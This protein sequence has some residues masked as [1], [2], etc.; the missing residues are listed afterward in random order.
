MPSLF[1]LINDDAKLIEQTLDRL[2]AEGVPYE[3]AVE[4]AV[5]SVDQM[6]ADK[7]LSYARVILSMEA[8]AESAKERAKAMLARGGARQAVADRMRLRLLELLPRDF[9]AEDAEVKLRFQPSKVLSDKDVK[10]VAVLSEQIVEVIPESRKVSKTKINELIKAG[11]ILAEEH[12][13]V[14]GEAASTV[15][16]W[17]LWMDGAL[18][19]GVRRVEN[20]SVRIS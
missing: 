12:I 7:A 17:D 11:V 8:F 19:E 10:D 5:A 2:E 4:R 20:Y 9:K 3:E 18:I 15:K 13:P 16:T 14:E 6:T 1:D